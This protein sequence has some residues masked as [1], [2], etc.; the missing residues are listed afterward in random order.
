[1]GLF[2]HRNLAGLNEVLSSAFLPLFPAIT[3]PGVSPRG[4][5]QPSFNVLY[6]DQTTKR[7]SE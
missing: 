4:R 3:A 6:Q 5:N 7:V 2:G 1:V